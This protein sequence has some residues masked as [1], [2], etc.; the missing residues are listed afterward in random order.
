MAI[1]YVVLIVGGILTIGVSA[2]I[3]KK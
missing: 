2:L 3:N 1:A